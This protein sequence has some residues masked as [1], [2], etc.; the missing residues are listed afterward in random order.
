M[1]TIL[2]ILLALTY[3]W[4]GISCWAILL[5]SD[6]T[7]RTPAVLMLTI[8]LWWTAPIAYFIVKLFDMD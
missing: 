7:S 1:I 5:D 3:I 8:L 6:P 2:I 4:A